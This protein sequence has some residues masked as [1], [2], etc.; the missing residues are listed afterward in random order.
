MAH[1]IKKMVY[2]TPSYRPVSPIT[3]QYF[4]QYW[5]LGED[6]PVTCNLVG[7]DGNETS[8]DNCPYLTINVVQRPVQQNKNTYRCRHDGY[9]IKDPMMKCRPFTAATKK[10]CYKCPSL[11]IRSEVNTLHIQVSKPEPDFYVSN[12]DFLEIM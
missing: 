1:G 8:C 11:E 12:P 10:Y 6:S 3:T 4:C 2:N 5:G 9:P 7:F